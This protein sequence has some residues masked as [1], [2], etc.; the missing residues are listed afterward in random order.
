MNESQFD[1]INDKLD[2]LIKLIGTQIAYE[3]DYRDQVSLLNRAGMHSKEIASVTNKSE[4]NVKVTLH[5]IKNRDM[6]RRGVKK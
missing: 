5:L 3:K 6:H 4:N 1:A 2:I